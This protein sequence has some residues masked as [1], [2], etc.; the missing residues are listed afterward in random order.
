M[1]LQK[2][3]S[4]SIILI[5]FCFPIHGMNADGNNLTWLQIMVLGEIEIQQ[6]CNSGQDF[7]RTLEKYKKAF[8]G[9]FTNFPLALF[10]ARTDCI[11]M[12]LEAGVKADSHTLYKALT[13]G[14]QNVVSILLNNNPTLY[15]EMI[16]D[17]DY[18]CSLDRNSS[19][20]F[21]LHRHRTPN[22]MK[23]IEKEFK[24]KCDE[25]CKLFDTLKKYE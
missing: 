23:K 21:L 15:E 11:E 19:H 1:R 13:L 20:Y 6:Q 10:A 25:Y 17:K 22:E 12:A 24:I 5:I 14:N 9:N 16:R 18:Y 7:K 4:S 8:D 3:L 2:S